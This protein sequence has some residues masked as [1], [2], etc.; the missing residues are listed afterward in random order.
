MG[1]GNNGLHNWYRKADASVDAEFERRKQFDLAFRQAGQIR[2]RI[3]PLSKRHLWIVAGL[4]FVLAVSLY[5]VLIDQK[6]LMV[7][8]NWGR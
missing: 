8:A 1:N 2:R 3:R 5:M 4:C 7:F 6:S